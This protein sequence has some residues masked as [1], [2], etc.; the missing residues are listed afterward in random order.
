MCKS[1]NVT[2]TFFNSK[3]LDLAVL[4]SIV[5]LKCLMETKRRDRSCAK[6][7]V[8]QL[9]CVSHKEKDL[10]CLFQSITDFWAVSLG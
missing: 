10:G 4:H 8:K 6:L 1:L 2:T 7:N 3:R 5:Q 9:W